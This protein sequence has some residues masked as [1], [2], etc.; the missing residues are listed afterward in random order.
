MRA[1]LLAS[2]CAAAACSGPPA[3]DAALCRDVIT[4]LCA[5]RCPDADLKLKLTGASDCVATLT[6]RTGCSDDGF[7]FQSRSAFV[8]CRL[9]IVRA[10]DA[11]T[12]VPDCDDV[13]D[14]FRLC[15]SMVDFFN[16]ASP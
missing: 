16:G 4:R 5:A 15:P 10:S 7:M 12:A 3:S 1:V 8:S 11:V 6:G 2:L 9:P 13:D 14:M